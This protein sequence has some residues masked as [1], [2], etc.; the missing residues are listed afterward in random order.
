MA[1]AGCRKLQL[2]HLNIYHENMASVM[3]REEIIFWITLLEQKTKNML[4]KKMD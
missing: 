2:M 3:K 1:T 4:L